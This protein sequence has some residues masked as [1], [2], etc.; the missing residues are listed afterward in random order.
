M[1][2]SIV[3]LAS[4][5]AVFSVHASTSKPTDAELDDWMAFLRSVSLP[6]TREVCGPLLQG[7]ANYVDVAGRWLESHGEAIRRGREFALAG[8]HKD[9]DFGQYHAAMLEDFKQKVL[10]RSDDARLSLCKESLEALQ[11]GLT[12]PGGA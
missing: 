5:L 3:F 6:V 9:R 7:E 11:K 1:K 10:A 12:Q 2:R 8:N 4:T